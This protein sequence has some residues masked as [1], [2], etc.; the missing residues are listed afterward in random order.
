[1]RTD[2]DPQEISATKEEVR[3]TLVRLYEHDASRSPSDAFGAMGVVL[4]ELIGDMIAAGGKDS[5]HREKLLEWFGTLVR[6][7]SEK[8]AK[9]YGKP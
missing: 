7:H 5:Q 8:S 1:M 4:S 9:R 3:K 6:D 2:F